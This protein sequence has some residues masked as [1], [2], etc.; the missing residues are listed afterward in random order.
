MRKESADYYPVSTLT[1]HNCAR[2]L[3]GC[4]GGEEQQQIIRRLFKK[5]APWLELQAAEKA[6][7][8]IDTDIS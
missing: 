8:R 5:A 6:A 7:V 4:D 2:K 1:L 3:R